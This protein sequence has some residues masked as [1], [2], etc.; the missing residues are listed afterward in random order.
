MAALSWRTARARIAVLLKGVAITSPATASILRVFETPPAQ[1]SDFPC[2]IILGAEKAI[3]RST[4]R[5]REYVAHLRLVVRDADLNRAAD[6]LDAFQEAI[7][8]TFDANLTI[9]QRITNLV[10]PEW[11]LPDAP[12]GGDVGGQIQQAA[13][14]RLTITFYDDPAFAAGS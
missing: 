6:L 7:D 10:G 3:D 11:G 8:D 13:D 1:V 9:G 14:A 12:T 4:T 5:R 2:I